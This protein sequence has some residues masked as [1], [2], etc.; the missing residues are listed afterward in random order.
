MQDCPAAGSGGYGAFRSAL[1]QRQEL[2]E[3]DGVLQTDD[4][5]SEESSIF[6]HGKVP[7]IWLVSETSSSNERESITGRP[8]GSSSGSSGSAGKAVPPGGKAAPPGGGHA[9][10]QKDLTKSCAVVALSDPGSD[11]EMRC[12]EI[13]DGIPKDEAGRLTSFGS[14]AHGQGTC[15]PCA[16]WFKGCCQNGVACHN[17]HFIHEGQRPKRLRPKQ[18]KSKGAASASD[19]VE[20]RRRRTSSARGWP[21]AWQTIGRSCDTISPGSGGE[22]CFFGWSGNFCNTAGS[23]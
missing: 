7:K 3:A 22:G 16:Y 21:R 13:L 12:K 23:V 5:E 6:E 1:Q 11:L 19:D 14:S 20:R 9:V 4:D 15:K 17:C 18:A 10:F 2:T 8:A